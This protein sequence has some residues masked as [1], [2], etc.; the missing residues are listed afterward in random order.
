M[1]PKFE[2][3]EINRAGLR[4]RCGSACPSRMALAVGQPGDTCPLGMK[5]PELSLEALAAI[6]VHEGGSG[7]TGH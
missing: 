2:R 7:R 6:V 3:P 1:V 4:G 5:K